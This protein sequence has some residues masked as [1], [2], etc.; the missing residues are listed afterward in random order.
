MIR[1]LIVED[2]INK[3]DQLNQFVAERFPAFAVENAESL[4]GGV[5]KLRSWNPDLVLLDMTLPN[6]DLEEGNL[7]ASMQAFG[8]EEF[9]RQSKRFNLRP[10]VIV[11]TQFETFGDA[12]E[13]KDRDELNAELQEAFPEVYCGMVYYHASINAWSDE[14]ETAVRNALGSLLADDHSGNRR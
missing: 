8:G 13:A 12:S 5:R 9:L 14:L 3:L 6:Y 2:D 7:N 1:L 4:I 11:V 10:R